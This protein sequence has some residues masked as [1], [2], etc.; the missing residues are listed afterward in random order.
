MITI[1]I[2]VTLLGIF[3][4]SAIVVLVVWKLLEKA[5]EED[6]KQYEVRLFEEIKPGMTIKEVEKICGVKPKWVCNVY[7]YGMHGKDT[8]SLYVFYTY[9]FCFSC[10]FFNGELI[11]KKLK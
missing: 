2:K 6:R 8:T 3:V 7:S 11:N 1:P 10:T 5:A 4:F 9:C